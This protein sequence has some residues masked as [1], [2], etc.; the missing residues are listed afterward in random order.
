MQEKFVF[1]GTDPD[2][3]RRKNTDRLKKI[4]RPVELFCLQNQREFAGQGRFFFQDW[5]NISSRHL[6]EY[7]RHRRP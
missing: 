3:P 5:S 4:V 2:M 7:I 1:H 6:K